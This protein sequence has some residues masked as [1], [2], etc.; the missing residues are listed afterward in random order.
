MATL[1]SAPAAAAANCPLLRLVLPADVKLV[2][3]KINGE[4][5]PVEGYEVEGK[6]LTIKAPPAGASS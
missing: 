5:L 2:S 3:V 4:A 1:V 6:G